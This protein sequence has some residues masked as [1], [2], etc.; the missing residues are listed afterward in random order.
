LFEVRENGEPGAERFTRHG[1][2]VYDRPLTE[3][4]IRAFELAV[5]ADDAL[6]DTLAADV[7]SKLVSYGQSYLEIW[8][9]DQAMFESIVADRLADVRPYSVYVGQ[10]PVFAAKVAENL[11]ALI[12]TKNGEV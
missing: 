11:A 10:V 1:V 9:E 6:R 2:I 4:E 8:R 3:S 12:E 7:A 5:L